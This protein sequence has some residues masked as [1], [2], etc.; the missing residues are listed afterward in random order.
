MPIDIDTIYDAVN[1]YY[2]LSPGDLLK[3]TRKKEVVEKRHV[4]LFLCCKHTKKS[5]N[6]I[7]YYPASLGYK[8]ID[9]ATVLH[10]RNKIKSQLKIY[11][12]IKEDIKGIEIFIDDLRKSLDTTRIVV[13]NVDLLAISEVNTMYENNYLK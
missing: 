1:A 11:K 13:R 4:F 8:K 2:D 6:E 3:N 9:H 5:L 10:A 12:D 7:G